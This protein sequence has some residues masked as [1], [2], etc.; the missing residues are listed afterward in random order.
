MADEISVR[1]G[2][3]VDKGNLHYRSPTSSTFNC[4]LAGDFVKQYSY[5]IDVT[6]Q[7]I[8][9]SM[10]SVP[11]V[12]VFYNYG[13]TYSVEYGIYDGNIFHP[14][15]IIKPG[16]CW[17]MR[18]SPNIG[19]EYNPGTG[20]PPGGVVNSLYFKT[21]NGTTPVSMDIFED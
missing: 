2:L 21:D 15:G 7:A 4:T 1:G 13:S 3:A 17:Q 12:A 6:G 14:F 19:T 11:G 9:L 8:D 5:E 10:L 20:T 18:L 16:E